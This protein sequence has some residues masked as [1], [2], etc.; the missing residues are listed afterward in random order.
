M[1]LNEGSWTFEPID[2]GR[3]TRIVYSLLTDPAGAIPKWIMNM[4]SVSVITQPVRRRA[5]APRKTLTDKHPSLLRRQQQSEVF[6]VRT[7]VGNAGRQDATR[8]RR[9]GAGAAIAHRRRR[10]IVAVRTGEWKS[11]VSGQPVVAH[12]PCSTICACS[13]TG[14]ADSRRF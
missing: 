14:W 2:E 12:A 11:N 3:R 5:E 10:E 6:T 7:T 9:E 8:I 4:S 1:R 13:P